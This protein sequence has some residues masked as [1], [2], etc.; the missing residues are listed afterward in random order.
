MEEKILEK[1]KTADNYISGEALSSLLNITRSAVWKHIKSLKN[2]GYKIEGISNRGYK[3]LSCP[4]ILSS[5]ELSPLLKTKTLGRNIIHFDDIDSTNTEAKKLAQNNAPSGSI[6]IS[7]T[8]NSGSG[9]FKRVWTSPKGGIWFTLILRPEI[10]PQQA[11]KITQIAAAAMNKTLNEKN[12]DTKIK[13]P[14]DIILNNKKICGILCEMK[15]DMDIIHYMIVGIGLNVNISRESF[16]DD[17]FKTA[18]SL[19]I[20][21]KKTFS[22]AEILAS[23][24]KNFEDMYDSFVEKNDLT[25]TINICR[26]NSNTFGR[27]AKLITLNNE[28]I[29]TCIG[30]SDSLNLI[31]KDSSGTER[32]ILSGEISFKTIDE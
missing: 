25:E 22:R 2:K 29:V 4:D 1:L 30:I 31:V 9:R 32:E 16:D 15:C 10:V 13:W 24:L 12:I 6:V 8:Q 11:P 14:N 23:F 28:E 17:L 7:E 26:E 19:M 5:N 27:K 18:S 3:L 20:E 21:K